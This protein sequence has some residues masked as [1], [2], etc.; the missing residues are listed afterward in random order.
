MPR[1]RILAAL[2]GL[3]ALGAVEVACDK[4]PAQKAGEKVDRAIDTDKAIG[5][6][7]VEKAGK[8]IDKA[9]EDVKK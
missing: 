5:K 9:A 2:A 8:E 4:G 6:G 1:S 3:L 7:P